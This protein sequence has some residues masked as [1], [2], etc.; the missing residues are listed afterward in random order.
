M[1]IIQ[2]QKSDSLSKKKMI[3]ICD[4]FVSRSSKEMILVVEKSLN[5]QR[6]WWIVF[7][8]FFALNVERESESAK[9][10]FEMIIFLGKKNDFVNSPFEL[11]MNSQKV[12]YTIPSSVMI[13]NTMT[14]WRQ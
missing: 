13:L 7:L 9:M 5:L 3:R 10:K 2:D 1:K 14:K 4:E 6:W 12:C 11:F 8:M